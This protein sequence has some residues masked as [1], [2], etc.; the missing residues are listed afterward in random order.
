[1]LRYI[2]YV[3]CAYHHIRLIKSQQMIRTVLFTNRFYKRICLHRLYPNQEISN[4]TA[5]RFPAKLFGVYF[6]L[7]SDYDDLNVHRLGQC[8]V[9]KCTRIKV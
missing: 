3:H 5:N 8:G 2:L 4:P 6:V 7:C 1:M 9:F